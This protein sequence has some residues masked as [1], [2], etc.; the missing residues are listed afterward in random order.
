MYPMMRRFSFF[1]LAIVTIVAVEEVDLTIRKYGSNNWKMNLIK[2]SYAIESNN[3]T[4]LIVVGTFSI[5]PKCVNRL[6][7]ETTRLFSAY[8]I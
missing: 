6:C 8:G 2:L 7:D 1:F 4:S 5:V 3:Y